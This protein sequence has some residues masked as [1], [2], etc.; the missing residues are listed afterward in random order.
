MRQAFF[1]EPEDQAGWM[2]HRWLT[3]QTARSRGED[4][5]AAA[6]AVAIFAGEADALAELCALDPKATAARFAAHQD[7][8]KSH[9]FCGDVAYVSTLLTVPPQRAEP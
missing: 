9:N 8:S 2:Y 1:T 6:A 7:A 3:A 5:A 4:S